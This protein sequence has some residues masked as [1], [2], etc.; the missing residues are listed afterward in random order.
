MD[1]EVLEEV[2]GWIGFG[3]TILYYLGPC[4]SFIQVLKGKKSYEETPIFFVASSYLNTFL[5]SIYGHLTFSDQVKYSHIFGACVSI[6]LLAIYILCEIDKFL[7]DSILNSLILITGTWAIYR[8]LVLVYEESRLAGKFCIGTSCFMYIYPMLILFKVLREKNYKLININSAFIY[9]LS[10][11]AW[12]TYGFL[13]FDN[14]LI[15]SHSIGITLSFFQIIIYIIF[16][17]KYPLIGEK[18]FPPSIVGIEVN[19]NIENKKEEVSIKID[20]VN[21]LP[22]TNEKPVKIISYN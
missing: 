9:L 17:M 6:C 13:A 2:S 18:D 1:L 14:Y 15:I 8:V 16:K 22:K 4:P 19:E 21:N 3:L 20:D 7:V 11:I 5:W 10:S 12:I